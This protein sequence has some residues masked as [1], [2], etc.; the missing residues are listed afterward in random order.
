MRMHM[1][2]FRNILRSLAD[3]ET[4]FDHRLALPDVPQ[5]HL[6]PHGQVFL[7]GHGS[8]AVVKAFSRFQGLQGDRY[9]I[10]RADSY[11]LVHVFLLRLSAYRQERKAARAPSPRISFRF[12]TVASSRPGTAVR[13]RP[14]ISSLLSAA[15][16]SC[17]GV[18]AR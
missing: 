17:S 1:R 7:Q 10:L 9:Q 8:A 18:S 5:G 2:P 12:R 14:H 15:C 13:S 11:Q 16:T 3:G 4:V 6:V